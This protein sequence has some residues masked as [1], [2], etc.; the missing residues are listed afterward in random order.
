AS[1]TDKE[2]APLEEAV[3]LLLR[4]KLTGRAAPAEAG[5]V[6]DLWREWIE[7]KAGPGLARLG[8]N[9]EDQQAFAR[10]VRDM[11]ASMD[12][13]EELSQEEQSGEQ[14]QDNEQTPDSDED[15][16]GGEESQEGSDSAESDES[17]SSSEEGEQGEMD[18]A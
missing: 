17:D 8:E 13:A 11:L 9:L 6:L 16:D 1:V 2:D 12:M 14:D 4:E 7:Q 10:T 5:P 3:S 15:E 18:A